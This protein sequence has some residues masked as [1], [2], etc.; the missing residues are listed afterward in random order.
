V[1]AITWFEIPTTDLDRAVQFYS[2]V[3]AQ[4][5]RKDEFGGVPHGFFQ[6]ENNGVGGALVLSPHHVPSDDRGVVIYL[7]AGNDLDGILSRVE[8]AGGKVTLPRTAI[9]P[10]GWFA[11]IRDTEGNR[12]GLHQPQS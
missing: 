1:N 10:Q 9:P 5:V 3:L 12:V 6:T 11:W 7:N 4:P 2:R 8:A